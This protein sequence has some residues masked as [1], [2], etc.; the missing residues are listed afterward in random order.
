MLMG[1]LTADPELRK[2]KTGKSVVTFSLATNNEWFDNEGELQK[3]SDFHRVVAWEGLAEVSKKYLKKGSAVFLEG[4]LSNR[5]YE[6]KDK[7][8]RF[9]TEVVATSLH[10]MPKGV[11]Q[12]ISKLEELAVA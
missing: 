11:Q 2:T 12:D 4:R 9:V 7:I 10:L 5:S 6:G 3:T 1:N 8:R